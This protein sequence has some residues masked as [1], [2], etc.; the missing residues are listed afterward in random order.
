MKDN[1]NIKTHQRNARI[2][3]WV[4]LIV[5]SATVLSLLFFIG[6]NIINDIQINDIGEVFAK[7]GYY[8]IILFFLC[9]IFIAVGFIISWY[10]SKIG[11][12]LVI[13]FTIL[14]YILWG[15][16]DINILLIHLPLLFSGFLLLFYS[17]YKEW[18]IKKEKE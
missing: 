4:A 1:I 18:I 16:V 7:D 17:C 11:A 15:E 9:E 3:Y 8:E 13:A 2:V 10:K 5:G 14:A 6:A 12:F